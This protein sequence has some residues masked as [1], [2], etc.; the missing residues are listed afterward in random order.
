MTDNIARPED[1]QHIENKDLYGR[2]QLRN[3]ENWLHFQMQFQADAPPHVS[4]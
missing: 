3:Q 2:R 4:R 1:K